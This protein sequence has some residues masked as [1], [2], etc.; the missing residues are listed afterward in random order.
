VAVKRTERVGPLIFEE[1]SRVLRNRLSD[2]RLVGLTFTKVKMTADL[3]I[4]RVYFSV[5]GGPEQVEAA[6]KA[7]AGAKGVFKG[8]I[9]RNLSLRYMP[10]LQF[11]YD[12]NLEYADKIERIIREIK[13]QEKSDS[14]NGDHEPGD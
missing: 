5:I 12:Q 10:D 4:A 11:Y 9:S 2:P 8:A 7:L 1:V 6:K 14:E 13:Q 3:K